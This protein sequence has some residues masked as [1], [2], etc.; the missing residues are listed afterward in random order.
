MSLNKVMLIGN[1]GH[2]KKSIYACVQAGG[3]QPFDR[4]ERLVHGSERQ[5]RRKRTDWLTVV[6]YGS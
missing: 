2:D 1:L 6:A 5:P 4:I 3:Y